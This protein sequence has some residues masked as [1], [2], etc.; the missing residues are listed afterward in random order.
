MSDLSFRSGR[1]DVLD[2]Q[3]ILN[4]FGAGAGLQAGER[5]ERFEFNAFV[6]GV[7]FKAAVLV[8]VGLVFNKGAFFYKS[9]ALVDIGQP[10]ARAGNPDFL[11]G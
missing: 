8:R 6:V 4:Q 9:L 5:R 1:L 11:R 7:N 3:P 10:A 2:Q